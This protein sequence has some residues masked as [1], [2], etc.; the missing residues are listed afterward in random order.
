MAKKEKEIKTNAMRMLDKHKIS[1]K[2]LQYECAEFIDGVHTAEATGAPPEQSFKTLVLQ[3]K[4]RQYYVFAL[5]VAQEIDLKG[6]ARLAGEKSLEMVP[7]K[8]ITAVTGYVRGGCSPLGMKKQYPVFLSKDA[9]AFD[10][11]YISGGRVGTTLC[12]KTADFLAVSK[13]TAG[14]FTAGGMRAAPIS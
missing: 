3:G 8:E 5:P 10:E 1:Y 12:L 11:L 13:A 6:A 9:L 14:E 2:V 7:V 4:S